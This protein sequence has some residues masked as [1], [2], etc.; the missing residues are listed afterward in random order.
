MIDRVQASVR[1]L[2][3]L[4]VDSDMLSGVGIVSWRG[5]SGRSKVS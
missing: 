4:E 2:E 1:E 3:G 5:G